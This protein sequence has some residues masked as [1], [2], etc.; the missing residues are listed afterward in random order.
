VGRSRTM[1]LNLL[2]CSFIL[3]KEAILINSHVLLFA[4]LLQSISWS[5]MM[6]SKAT[7]LIRVTFSVSVYIFILYLT[8]SEQAATISLFPSTSISTKHNRHPPQG[9]SGPGVRHSGGL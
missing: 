3:R 1:L 7:C 6:S 4:H 9:R 5:L 8:G 2:G